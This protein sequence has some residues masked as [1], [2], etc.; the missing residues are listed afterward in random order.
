MPGHF[1]LLTFR[2]EGDPGLPGVTGPDPWKQGFVTQQGHEGSH[3]EPRAAPALRPGH[4]PHRRP[5]SESRKENP[6]G[7]SECAYF[8]RKN[9]VKRL[10]LE[11][12][13]VDSAFPK[14]FRGQA[15]GGGGR[16]MLGTCGRRN[17]HL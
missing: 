9:S 13:H 5:G 10:L 1:G 6:T 4:A 7:L 14:H 3:A 16:V 2:R 11:I 17:L 15:H 12:D 8:V